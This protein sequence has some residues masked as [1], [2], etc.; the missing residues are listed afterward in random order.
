MDTRAMDLGRILQHLSGVPLGHSL[1]RFLPA[2]SHFVCY[3]PHMVVIFGPPHMSVP[4][5]TYIQLSSLV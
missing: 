5:T 2:Y 3:T 4:L 1:W